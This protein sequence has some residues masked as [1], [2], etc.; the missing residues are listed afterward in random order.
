[1]VCFLLKEKETILPKEKKRVAVA[2]RTTKNLI[3]KKIIMKVCNVVIYHLDEEESQPQTKVSHK[4]LTL[5]RRSIAQRNHSASLA[6]L[7]LDPTNKTKNEKR[8]KMR[9]MKEK[10][11]IMK[12]EQIRR[13]SEHCPNFQIILRKKY[14]ILK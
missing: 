7:D 8:K 2:K 14:L 3:Q 5:I 4:V 9:W 11:M 1:M 10:Y 13:S 12:F 6:T